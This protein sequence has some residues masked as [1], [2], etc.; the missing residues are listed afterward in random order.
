MRRWLVAT[1]TRLNTAI[2]ALLWAASLGFLS[3]SAH[4]GDVIELQELALT[5]QRPIGS[6]TDPL[7]TE[8]QNLSPRAVGN[9]FDLTVDTRIFH[10]V[11]WDSTIHSATDLVVNPDGSTAGGQFREVGLDTRL[12]VQLFDKLQAG[13]YHGSAH[14]LDTVYSGGAWPNE[15]GLEVRF[16]IFRSKSTPKSVF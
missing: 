8:N 12:G 3:V 10:Y 15:T 4:A 14:L 5:Y 9:R 16:T 11:Y 7:L 2:K 1:R 6:S 13:V